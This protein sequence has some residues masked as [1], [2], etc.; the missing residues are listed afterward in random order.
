[1]Y[2]PSK[3][4][5]AMLNALGMEAPGI[6]W[7][8]QFFVPVGVVIGS[9]DT[10][11][12]LSIVLA[13]LV[14]L[15]LTAAAVW[16]LSDRRFRT[17]VTGVVVMAS[18]PL[19]IGLSHYYLVEMMQTTAVAWFVLIMALAPG[20]SRLLTAS[21]LVLATSFAML[22][23]VSS[24]LYCLGPGLV[25]LYYFVRPA[26]NDESD[27]RAL[28]W[29][30]RAMLASGV[31]LGAATA[32]WYF[33]NIHIVVEHVAMA[34][35]GSVAELYGKQ[36]QFLLSMKYWLSA[37]RAAFFPPAVAI[38]AVGS[39]LAA[40]V[41]SLVTRQ[42]RSRKFALAV[43]VAVFE[44][45]T[46]LSVFSVNA[47]R[48]NRYLL[49]LLPYVVLILSWSVHRVDRR[50]VTYAVVG[51]FALGWADTHAQSLGLAD[52]DRGAPP[53][54]TARVSDARD[55]ALLSSIVER[56]CGEHTSASYW[57]AVGVQLIWLNPPGVSYAAAKALAPRHM[58]NCQFDAIGYYDNNEDAAWSRLMSERITYY[59]AVDPSA[60]QA[61]TTPVDMTV[62]QLDAPILKRIKDSGVFQLKGGI[63]GRTDG[64][65]GVLIFER[66]DRVDHIAR[67]RE[68]FDQ[69]KY[70]QA[71][72]EYNKTAVLDPANV[73]A[74]AN[75]A[76]AY[77]RAGNLEQAV[78]A[79]GRA[80]A[81]NPNHY[82]VNMI[83]AVSFMQ[84]KEWATAV[85][86]AEDAAVNAPGI[87]ERVTALVVAAQAS[88]QARDSAKGCD[89][90]RRAAGVQRGPDILAEIARNGCGT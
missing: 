16:E 59:V 41:A 85:Q 23:K 48:D 39:L 58:L 71:I 32:C 42:A 90:L 7:L 14:A 73:E 6:A 83:L 38:C 19:F 54:L 76:Q 31:V 10:G 17:A 18:A 57:N 35:S 50:F 61:P 11:L 65:Q 88:F 36:E 20:W 62:N 56:T 87:R 68:L 22:A 26:T 49:P 81:L 80:R 69:G 60:Y 77:E 28:V 33:R 25:A 72:D 82:Y 47:N 3:W 79:G 34:S 74:W 40:I 4:P 13:Q 66:V 29:A 5:L 70:Q 15:L 84:E 55:R 1:V 21:Q 12:L 9:I 52:L 30:L 45:A 43:G 75:L 53:W 64:H 89:F 78:V 8:G 2:S 24:P 51:V 37:L 67:G 44:I 46:V 86:R 27:S 63:D